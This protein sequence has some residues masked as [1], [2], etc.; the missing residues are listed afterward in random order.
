MELTLKKLVA[1][2]TTGYPDLNFTE[3]VILS[4]KEAGAD[5][6]ELGIPFSD[7]V[8]DG[9]VIEEANLKSLELGFKIKDLFEVSQKVAKEIDTLWMGYFNPFYQKTMPIMIEEAKKAGIN[10]FII[11]DLPYEEASVYKD[12]VEK[13]G[14]AL[15]DFV[16]PTD[17]KER[18]KQIVKNSKKFIYMVAYAGIT[19]SGKNEDL[20]KVIEDVRSVTDTPLYIGFGVNTKTAKEKSKGV[21]GVIVGSEFVKVLLNDTLSYQEKIENISQIAKEIK[22]KINS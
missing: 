1:Y 10:G 6:I 22:E 17:S 15:I 9:P 2:I 7:P 3:D 12:E 18:I 19:G 8:A 20:T 21:D 14:L 4:L 11:P 13:N 16:A 5:T